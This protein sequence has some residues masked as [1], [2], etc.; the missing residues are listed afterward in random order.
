MGEAIV[1][2]GLIIIGISY[3]LL[4]KEH[5]KRNEMT[6]SEIYPLVIE[7]LVMC[8]IS[9]ILLVVAIN[10]IITGYTYTDEIKEVIKEL[11]IGFSIIILV[12][13]HFIY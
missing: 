5:H 10:C 9:G 1:V 12:I 4:F 3:Y 6:F 2:L 13:I 11:A 8:I 7:Y